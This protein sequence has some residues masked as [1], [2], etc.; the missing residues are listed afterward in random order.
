E[1]VDSALL[2]AYGDKYKYYKDIPREEEDFEKALSAIELAM[3]KLGQ[4]YA[5]KLDEPDSAIKTFEGMLDRFGD[6]SD[7]TLRARYALY[8]LYLQE[9][10][11]ALAEVQK[12]VILNDHP[13]TVYAYLILGKDPNEL[14]EEE[15]DFRFAYGGL[16]SSYEEEQYET[17]LGFSEFLLAQA[18]FADNP[19]ELDL[20][21]LY[22][23]KGMS[24]GFLGEKDSLRDILTYVV[25]NYPAHEVTPIAQQTLN[26]MTK[27]LPKKAAPTGGSGDAVSKSDPRF[28]GF[29]EEPGTNDK[30]FVLLYIDKTLITRNEAT[31]KIANFNKSYY[32]EKKLKAFVFMYKQTHLLPY[33]SHFKT[34]E[35][36]QK[37]IDGFMNDDV[38]KEIMKTGEE[39]IFYITNTNFKIAYGQKRMTDYLAYYEGILTAE[40]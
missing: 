40:E 20:A 3:Y 27:G 33:I 26:Y 23:I 1:P 14:K 21:R 29:K 28:K 35:E 11:T 6:D 37:Y 4:V 24:Y 39:K 30:V 8:N 18:E 9:G 19:D 5:Q 25:S 31:T 17:S 16:F 36:A 38:S 34:I 10:K 13:K 2:K 32:K 15:A 22:Y 12:S 7:Y